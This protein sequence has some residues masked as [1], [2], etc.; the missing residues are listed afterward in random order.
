MDPTNFSD[1]KLDVIFSKLDPTKRGQISQQE[2]R[3]GFLFFMSQG[4][5]DEVE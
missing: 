2:F 5:A 4:V 3:D 1:E